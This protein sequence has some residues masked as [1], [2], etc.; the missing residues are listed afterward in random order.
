MKVRELMTKPAVT[1]RTRDALSAAAH[2]MWT[3][4]CGALPAIDDAGRL[5]G[6]VTDRDI[7]MSAYMQGVP[8]ADIPVSA[9]MSERSWSCRPDDSLD[10]AERIMT[11]HQVRRVPVVNEHGHP[12][13]VIALN[14]M[15][16]N[17]ASARLNGKGRERLT[18]V[19]AAVGQGRG[20]G[21]TLPDDSA[22]LGARPGP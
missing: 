7:C 12:V 1:C 4:D 11:Q 22:S 6:M 17:A 19:L 14:D 8:L 10:V 9:A 15:V 2:H 18:S 21:V 16:R 13:G 20:E 5:A 3:H